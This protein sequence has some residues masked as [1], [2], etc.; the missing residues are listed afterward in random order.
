M[1]RKLKA[2]GPSDMVLDKMNAN[3]VQYAVHTHSL[4]KRRHYFSSAFLAL[5][6]LHLVRDSES[7]LMGTIG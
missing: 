2:P 7:E 3:N 4:S 1:T 6:S 5:S